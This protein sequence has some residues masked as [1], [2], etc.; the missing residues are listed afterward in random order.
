MHAPAHRVD[1]A[2]VVRRHHDGRAGAVDAV[3]QPHDADRGRRVEV[4]GRLV[5]EEDQR[6]VDERARDRHPLLLTTRQLGREVVGLLGEADEVEDLRHLRAH[7]VLRPADHLER[8]RDVLVDRL[9]GEQLEVLED[10]ADVAPQLRHLPRAEAPDVAAR[11]EDP[12]RGRDL[13]AQQQL[14]ERRLPRAR[15]PDEEDELALQ[16]LEGEVAEGDD[17]AFVDL[18][19]VFETNH[20]RRSI[21]RRERG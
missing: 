3:E 6:P 8:E 16:D 12:A 2:L 5:G 10:A 18:G 4:S 14:Q 21:R 17:V 13:V 1:D 15:G 9:V 20:V 19:D 11:D 7:D